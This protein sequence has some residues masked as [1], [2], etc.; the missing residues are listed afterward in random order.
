[1][2]ESH[3]SGFETVGVVRLRNVARSVSVGAGILR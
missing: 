1:L 2:K 3:A